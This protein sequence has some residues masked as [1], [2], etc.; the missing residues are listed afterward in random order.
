MPAGRLHQ[1]LDRLMHFQCTAALFFVFLT[2]V[3]KRK[4]RKV[5]PFFHSYWLN[6]TTLINFRERNSNSYRLPSGGKWQSYTPYTV[7]GVVKSY[8]LVSLIANPKNEVGH[9]RL[10]KT[11]RNW[12]N[13]ANKDSEGQCTSV[14]QWMYVY[15]PVCVGMSVNS[16]ILTNVKSVDQVAPPYSD[17][18]R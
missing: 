17:D 15:M 8:T 9:T 1:I 18:M 16:Q 2:K 4:K 6:S 5:T 3:L 13:I 12:L 7:S 10:W 14:C 11:D